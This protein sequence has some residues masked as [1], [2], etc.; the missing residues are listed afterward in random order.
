MLTPSSSRSALTPA[1]RNKAD[2]A[3]WVTSTSESS[4]LT[5]DGTANVSSSSTLSP[6][7]QLSLQRKR[8]ED[9]LS[10]PQHSASSIPAQASFAERSRGAQESTSDDPRWEDRAGLERVARLPRFEMDGGVSLSGGR[11][12]EEQADEGASDAGVTVATMPPPYF[13]ITYPP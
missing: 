10:V 7:E 8:A 6:V 4:H 2:H 12:G 9:L 13:S 3:A 11:P 1:Q 5:T